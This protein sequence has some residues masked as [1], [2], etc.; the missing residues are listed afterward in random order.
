MAKALT[1]SYS[2]RAD[3][4]NIHVGRPRKAILSEIEDEIYARLD[5]R[6][7]EV[8]GFTVLN[9]AARF[10]ARHRPKFEQLPLAASFSLP[11][12]GRRA[13]RASG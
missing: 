4:L 1:Y 8:I 11:S 12:S 2:P 7:N 9:L 5:P 13:R 10:R 6:T 3:E